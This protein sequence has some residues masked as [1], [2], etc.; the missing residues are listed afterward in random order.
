MGYLLS[1]IRQAIIKKIYCLRMWREGNSH[2]MMKE[3]KTRA[4]IPENSMLDP[5]TIIESI[6]LSSGPA[7][8]DWV[9]CIHSCSH[10]FMVTIKDSQGPESTCVSTDGQMRKKT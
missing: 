10:T 6:D 9:D 1:F 2:M 5:Q 4:G 3:T 7:T 8:R